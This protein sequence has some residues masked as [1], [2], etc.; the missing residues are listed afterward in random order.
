MG[1]YQASIFPT[2]L[3]G[4]A[5]D[6]NIHLFHFLSFHLET[7]ANL[8]GD[9]VDMVAPSSSYTGSPTSTA[10]F[11]SLAFQLN[12]P[13][14]VANPGNTATEAVGFRLRF[15][16]YF[17]MYQ[18][19]GYTPGTANSGA[20]TFS[21]EAN[22]QYITSIYW[23]SPG[24]YGTNTATV[25]YSDNPGTRFFRFCLFP[26]S[27]GSSY[28]WGFYEL[29]DTSHITAD[30]NFGWGYFAPG[31]Y[32]SG[33]VTNAGFTTDSPPP[34]HANRSAISSAYH[35]PIDEADTNNAIMRRN[36]AFYDAQDTYMGKA[37]EDQ[38]LW[39][40][41]MGDRYSSNFIYNGKHYAKEGGKIYSRVA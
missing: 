8:C 33:S 6:P 13:A 19:I 37:G 18:W 3:D 38:L 5:Q 14:W 11:R 41:D 23:P 35:Q 29:Q 30:V 28:E 15:D 40:N 26:A 2:A 27:Y 12:S 32:C 22:L 1:F 24:T 31:Y 9:Y 21:K 10:G 20:G 7:W 17:R 25:Y 34:R 36:S 39:S 4:A 16:N